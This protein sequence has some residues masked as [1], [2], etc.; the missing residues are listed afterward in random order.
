MK[1]PNRIEVN[2]DAQTGGL[3]SQCSENSSAHSRNHAASRRTI[4]P[5]LLS[6]HPETTHSQFTQFLEN[7]IHFLKRVNFSLSCTLCETKTGSG[8]VPKSLR[9]LIKDDYSTYHYQNRLG[10][11]LKADYHPCPKDSNCGQHE[12]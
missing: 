10:Y 6:S 8:G 9:N 4:S 5:A 3:I 2:T 1:T 7:T 12:G 11:N